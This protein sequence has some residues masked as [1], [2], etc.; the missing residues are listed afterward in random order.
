MIPEFPKFKKLE[1]SDK[2]AVESFTSKYLPYSDF[3]FTSLWSWNIKD[4]MQISK[5]EGNLAVKFNDYVTGKPFYS[6]LGA[7]N[8]SVAA[9]KLLDLSASEG[10]VPELKLLAEETVKVINPDT[11]II[12]E[13]RDNFDY[14]LAIERLKNFE[15]GKFVS[16]RNYLKQFKNAYTPE[17]KVINLSDQS[18]KDQIIKLFNLW[19]AHKVL[20]ASYNR[21]EFE[22][23]SRF[24]QLPSY[25]SFISIGIFLEN[26]I[27]AF[28]LLEKINADT[29]IS[30]YEK[31][32]SWKYRGIYPYLVNE[33][34]KILDKQKI[35][36]INF[37]Q[38]LGIAGLRESKKSYF[39]YGYLKQ[40]TIS[41]R[42]S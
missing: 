39:P 7:E 26:K 34:A 2:E 20:K 11:F 38:D 17:I 42:T 8:A 6:F 32:D 16:K 29:C 1:L 31:A 9:Q 24:L 25:K 35:K 21:H 30:H 14:F 41:Y 40:F 36:Y 12:S 5:L 3:N 15:G 28:W 19:K 18:I 13:D 33:T 22:S 37:E 4:Q 10:L 23:L 27:I